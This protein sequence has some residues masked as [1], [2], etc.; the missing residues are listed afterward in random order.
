MFSMIAI[1]GINLLVQEPLDGRNGMIVAIALGLGFG[2][3][4]VPEVLTF[5]PEWVKLLFG[6]SGIVIASMVALILNVI[7]PKD[8][9]NEK[10]KASKGAKN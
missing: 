8:D 2:L 1:S 3:G 6:G 7:L 10:T 9:V 4:S 5:M